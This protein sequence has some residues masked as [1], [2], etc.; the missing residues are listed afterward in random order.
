MIDYTS[1]AN[2]DP[3]GDLQLA[4]ESMTAET[5]E[6]AQDRKVNYVVIA[7]EA[8][9]A[10]AGA[11]EARIRAKIAANELP[12][13]VHDALKSGGLNINDSQLETQLLSMV[14]E[15]SLTTAHANKIL[16]LKT[17]SVAKYPQLREQSHLAKA[18]KLRVEGK[19]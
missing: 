8:G 14:D 10:E 2:G 16:T 13:W 9:F 11:L 17:V 12:E 1:I 7:N 4:F 5:V 18:R 6:Q 19:I 15:V 3:G